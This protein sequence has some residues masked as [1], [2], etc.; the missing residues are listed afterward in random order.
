MAELVS[1][2]ETEMELEYLTEGARNI[3]NFYH[4][5][6]SQGAPA[7]LLDELSLVWQDLEKA[8]NRLKAITHCFPPEKDGTTS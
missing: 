1:K 5:A 2:E 3:A 6:K 4:R 7:P 8:K